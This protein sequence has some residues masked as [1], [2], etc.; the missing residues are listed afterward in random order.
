MKKPQKNSKELV[1]W[2]LNWSGEEGERELF[3]EGERVIAW[4]V[5]VI[6]YY[7]RKCFK[8][9]FSSSK[10]KNHFKSQM[11]FESEEIEKEE[12]NREEEEDEKREKK[13]RRRM[14]EDFFEF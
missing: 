7:L 14:R 5:A 9:L 3:V 6:C 12:E 13:R 2:Y 11:R 8:F 10:N 1:N 4:V